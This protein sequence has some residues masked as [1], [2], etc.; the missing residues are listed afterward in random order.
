[1]YQESYRA[2]RCSDPSK[3]GRHRPGLSNSEVD[4]PS[5]FPSVHFRVGPWLNRLF[6][7]DLL[8]VHVCARPWLNRLS[9]FE[10]L[11]VNFRAFLWLNRPFSFDLRSVHF[12]VFPWQIL[13]FDLAAPDHE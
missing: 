11:S 5:V 12:R 7:F 9:G 10:L 1:M 4:L 3:L 13:I 8:S 2:Y 6:A